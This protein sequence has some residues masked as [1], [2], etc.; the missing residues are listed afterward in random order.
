VAGERELVAQWL[1][2]AAAESGER[3]A[4]PSDLAADLISYGGAVFWEVPRSA[5]RLREAARSLAL[6]HH[7]EAS[8][9]DTGHRDTCHRDAGPPGDPAPQPVALAALTRPAAGSVRID[10]LYTLPDRR[11]SGYGAGLT[12]AVS[13]ALLW[14]S[15]LPGV[16]GDDGVREVV[17]ITDKNR[18]DRWGSRF[19]YQLVGERSVL[20]FGPSAGPTAR[21]RTASQP[22]LP[23]GPLPRL[24]RLR[25]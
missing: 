23:T 4:A 10:H 20:R 17:M 9:R 16:L 3:L 8:H 14:G 1:T 18:P 19:G 5:G 7:R 15:G 25:G 21:S 11:R 22:R 12:Q 13:R 24:P 6:P 2:A